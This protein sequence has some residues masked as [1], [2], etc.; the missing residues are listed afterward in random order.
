MSPVIG[1]L[2][3]V[4]WETYN[5]SPWCNEGSDLGDHVGL[6]TPAW[7]AHCAL[8]HSTTVLLLYCTSTAAKLRTGTYLAASIC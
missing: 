3:I 7:G 1:L 5:A 6:I 4:Q 2:Y 8:R